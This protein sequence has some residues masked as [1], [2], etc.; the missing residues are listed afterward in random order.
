MALAEAP[1][2]CGSEA[3][4]RIICLPGRG[5]RRVFCNSRIPRERIMA[6]F[7]LRS[8]ISEGFQR[9]REVR[10]RN[11]SPHRAG[12]KRRT[13]G[14]YGRNDTLSARYRSSIGSA[15][16]GDQPPTAIRAIFAQ[17]HVYRAFILLLRLCYQPASRACHNGRDS[18]AHLEC[19]FTPMPIVTRRSTVHYRRCD[20]RRES[21]V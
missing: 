15:R 12:R 21:C 14:R 17:L 5:R 6:W 13:S 20:P 2:H 18:R 9:L 7:S 16:R 11:V 3:P 10:R 8:G 4:R 19:L 1:T